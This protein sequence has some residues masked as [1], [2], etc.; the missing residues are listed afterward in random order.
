MCVTGMIKETLDGSGVGVV[1]QPKIEFGQT[2]RRIPAFAAALSRVQFTT[3]SS[4]A[5][6]IVKDFHVTNSSAVVTIVG[7]R[8]SI[9][10]VNWIACL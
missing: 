1:K 2:F 10:S 6:A 7:T 8:C 4:Y 3:S 9:A 5:Y